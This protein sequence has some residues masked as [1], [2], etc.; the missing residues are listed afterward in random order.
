MEDGEIF[1]RELE[2]AI[3]EA[4]WLTFGLTGCNAGRSRARFEREIEADRP[5]VVL[6]AFVRN[7]PG[8]QT[9]PTAASHREGG[10]AGELKARI[11][12]SSSLADF[13]RGRP[14]RALRDWCA[15]PSEPGDR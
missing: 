6:F 12:R 14:F 1:P 5:D 9:L 8:R 10:R 2:R 11:C 15:P 4:E 3:P 7:D 13:D